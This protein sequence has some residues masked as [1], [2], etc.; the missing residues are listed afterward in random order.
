MVLLAQTALG[1]P[2]PLRVEGFVA[3]IVLLG[4][5][6]Q[7]LRLP[8]QT[9]QVREARGTAA[10]AHPHKAIL[11]AIPQANVARLAFR[12]VRAFRNRDRDGRLVPFVGVVFF[13]AAAAGY[14][15]A[16]VVMISSVLVPS[17]AQI[18]AIS[19]TTL[20]ASRRVVGQSTDAG[21]A[22]RGKH[23]VFFAGRL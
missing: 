10:C 19:R 14:F 16:F 3:Q 12:V 9:R 7:N 22:V 23:L 11:R 15:F 18:A 20:H 13:R 6:D 17:Q 2:S 5:R 8:H 4:I 21:G 1:P